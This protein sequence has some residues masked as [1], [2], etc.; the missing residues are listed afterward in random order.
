MDNKNEDSDNHNNNKEN[1]K[2]ILENK[3]FFE[4]INWFTKE[5]NSLVNKIN[6]GFINSDNRFIKANE[7]IKVNKNKDNFS[8]IISFN[9]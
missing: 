7:D 8:K 5:K 1:N 4:L 3:K 6:I 9:L 2:W